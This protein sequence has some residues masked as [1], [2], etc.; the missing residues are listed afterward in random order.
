[1]GRNMIGVHK[2]TR[3]VISPPPLIYPERYESLHATH[4]RLAQPKYFAH[5]IL[6]LLARYSP[7]AKSLN[8]QG[9]QLNLANHLA[10]ET[11]LPQAL[12]GPF[13]SSTELFGRP[14]KCY[15]TG[16]ITHR[17]AFQED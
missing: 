5:A 8:L 11:P 2:P 17:S 9:R 14:L 10:V 7:R 4:S 6:K 1:M 3:A 13:L 12:E 15:V 16:D